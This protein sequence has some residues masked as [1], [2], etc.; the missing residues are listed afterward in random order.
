[1]KRPAIFLDRDGVI[2]EEKHF[3]IDSSQ[4]EFV[5][6]AIE[7]LKTIDGYLKIVISNQSGVARGFFTEE[8]V[9]KFQSVLA[10]ILT[11]N[12]IRIDSW[13]FC[14][15]G[16]DDNCQC[17]KPSPGMI[18]DEAGKFSVDLSKS[19]MIGD[20]RSDI[21]AGKAAGL[22]TI[23]VM[24]GYGGSEPDSEP[25][26]P[27]FEVDDLKQAVEIIQSAR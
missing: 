17:R 24:T 22:K 27:D 15:H 12:G 7:A 25:V 26:E 19:W 16:P 21:A 1:M 13:R 18:L 9:I 4:I 23:L 20:K 10:G 5:P 11:E 3:L 2:I 14:P 6:G 8:D